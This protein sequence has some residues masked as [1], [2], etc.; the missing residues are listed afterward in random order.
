MVLVLLTQCLSLKMQW[1]SY[2]N[3]M[4]SFHMSIYSFESGH[5]HKICIFYQILKNNWMV[6]WLVEVN[7]IWLLIVLVYV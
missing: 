5:P 7:K 4:Y 3:G 2:D 6:G 1:K